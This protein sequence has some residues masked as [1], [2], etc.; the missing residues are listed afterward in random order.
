MLLIVS[1]TIIPYNLDYERYT[2]HS[3]N[4]LRLA[5]EGYV[6][7]IER[8]ALQEG[9]EQG[10][11]RSVLRVLVQRFGELPTDLGQRL[12]VFDPDGL[13]QLLDEAVMAANLDAFLAQMEMLRPE[14][15]T[16]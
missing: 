16:Q 15:D 11:E 5:L 10:L 1:L 8:R 4:R 3:T 6:T 12:E 2:S 13:E 9:L 14:T 7:S